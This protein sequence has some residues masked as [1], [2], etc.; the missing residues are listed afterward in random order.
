[1]EEINELDVIQNCLHLSSEY[2]LTSEV[3]WSAF[4][5]LKENPSLTIEDCLFIGLGEW[6]II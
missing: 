4:K 6:D 5:A 1:M 3:F 2:N